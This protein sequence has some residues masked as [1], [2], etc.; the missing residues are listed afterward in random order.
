MNNQEQSSVKRF[1]ISRLFLFI[2]IP[3]AGLVFFG[4]VRSYYNGYKINQEIKTLQQEISSLEKKKIE[5][6]TILEYVMSPG[7]VED[8]ARTELNMKKPGE[9]VLVVKNQVSYE[10]GKSS[11]VPSRQ[12][13]NNP[14]KWWYYFKN[15]GENLTPEE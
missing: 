2:T 1:F 5:S 10:V 14:L 3:V 7:F 15:K 6:M 4:Y 9:R 8:T 13:L 11:V 12:Q